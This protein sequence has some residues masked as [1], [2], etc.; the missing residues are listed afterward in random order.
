MTDCCRRS[1]QIFQKF[2]DIAKVWRYCRKACRTLIKVISL[3]IAEKMF[4]P[5]KLKPL[6]GHEEAEIYFLEK[7]GAFLLIDLLEHLPRVMHSVVLTALIELTE[8]TALMTHLMTW[9]SR[10]RGSYL[11]LIVNCTYYCVY[12]SNLSFI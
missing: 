9:K 10:K 6:K 11:I 1:L 7:E 8:N 4:C 3:Q 2:G 12:H 5:K